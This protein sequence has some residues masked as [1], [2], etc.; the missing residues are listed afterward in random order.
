MSKRIVSTILVSC[1]AQ[2][3]SRLYERHVLR[4]AHRRAEHAERPEDLPNG[5]FATKGP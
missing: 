2:S 5:T 4:A 3:E 1:P